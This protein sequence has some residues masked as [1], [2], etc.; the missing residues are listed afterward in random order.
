MSCELFSFSI[1][2]YRDISVTKCLFAI[3]LN[4]VDTLLKI[5]FKHLKIDELGEL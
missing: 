5:P 2:L 3:N 4:K 1:D